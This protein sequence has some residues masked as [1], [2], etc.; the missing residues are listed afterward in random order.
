MS[1]LVMIKCPYCG[2]S[3]YR[4]GGTTMSLVYYPPIYK[5]GVNINP[6]KNEY[7]TQCQCLHCGKVFYVVN[8]EVVKGD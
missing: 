1:K 2:K 7:R 8:G 3:H 6:D 4:M 5:D